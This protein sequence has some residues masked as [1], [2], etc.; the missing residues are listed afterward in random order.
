MWG[1]YG[2]AAGTFQ[3]QK[4]TRQ[5]KTCDKCEKGLFGT[6]ERNSVHPR[7]C[8]CTKCEEGKYAPSGH[9]K[10]FDCP[11][12]RFSVALGAYSCYYCPVGRYQQ[13]TGQNQCDQVHSTAYIVFY[14]D[15]PSTVSFRPEYAEERSHNKSQNIFGRW[16]QK[17]RTSLQC[18]IIPDDA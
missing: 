17:R 7:D 14:N 18:R 1:C 10:C 12:G 15:C 2:C 3:D 5:C 11:A 6:S 4:A 13:Q 16:V 9:V 8:K